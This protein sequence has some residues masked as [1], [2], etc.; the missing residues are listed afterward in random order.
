[1]FL[2]KIKNRE[3]GIL[4]YGITPPKKITPSEKIEESAKRTIERVKSLPI[5]ALIV[6][7]VQD[8]STRTK[9]ERPFPFQ[10]SV[11]PLVF[12]NEHLNE[13]EVEKIIYRPAGIYSEAE[14][15]EWFK[16]LHEQK[17]HP[18]LVG[19]P[20][21]DYVPKSTLTQAYELWSKYKETSVV[22]AISIPERHIVLGDEDQRMLDK[23]NSGV[24]YFVTQCVF[25]EDYSM[26]MLEALAA[27]CAKDGKEAPTVIFTLST[28]GSTK[29]LGFLEWLG[30][31]IK[32]EH[33]TRLLNS[34]S[35]LEDSI[36]LCVEIADILS[37]YCIEKNIPFGFNIESVA[38]KKEEIEASIT[39]LKQVEQM[40]KS[41]M[42]SAE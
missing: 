11:D 8:E 38:I 7:D 2:Q 5:D 15:S 20:S 27:S 40:L 36:D 29:I 13:L 16:N 39:L 9:E 22:G 31:H 25:N 30:I 14:L 28:C 23:I 21:P 1:M 19:I 12:V 42:V 17:A 3:S 24:S 26:D 32:E 35:I 18:V 41:K 34:T 4:V 37:N 10:A 33:K 6:Y